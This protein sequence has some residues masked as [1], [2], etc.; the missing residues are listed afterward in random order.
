MTP[1]VLYTIAIDCVDGETY[2]L[3]SSTVKSAVLGFLKTYDHEGSSI[4]LVIKRGTPDKYTQEDLDN[5]DAIYKVL[6]PD[7]EIT[8]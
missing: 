8:G 5:P 4:L 1:T 2:Y 7:V 3:M 6:S